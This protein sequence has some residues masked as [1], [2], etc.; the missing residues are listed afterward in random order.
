LNLE[1][2]ISEIIHIPQQLHEFLDTIFHGFLSQFQLMEFLP[3]LLII[4]DRQIFILEILLKLL[5]F[6]LPFFNP[7]YFYKVFPPNQGS[8]VQTKDDDFG[9]L[10]LGVVMNFKL[11]FHSEN[12]I[13]FL[14]NHF[15]YSVKGSW[16]ILP[17][18]LVWN[19][20]SP[21]FELRLLSVALRAIIGVE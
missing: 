6:N 13:F 3:F 21:S 20:L 14:L 4:P 2:L 17:K 11:S 16:Y 12:P 5:P 18:L 1:P 9:L 7:F 15:I 10:L 8:T 19:Y